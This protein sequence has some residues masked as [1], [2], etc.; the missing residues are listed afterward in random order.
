MKRSA[1]E[2]LR[3]SVEALDRDRHAP[4]QVASAAS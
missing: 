1:Q 3:P 4:I 2:I